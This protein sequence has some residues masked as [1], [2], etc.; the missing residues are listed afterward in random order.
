MMIL[1]IAIAIGIVGMFATVLA[2]RKTEL[3]HSIVPLFII[4]AFMVLY[5]LR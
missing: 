2:D 5:L 1:G 3:P 4:M